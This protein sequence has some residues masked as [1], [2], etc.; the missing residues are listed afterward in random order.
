MRN[1]S[2]VSVCD[3]S[4]VLC[5]KCIRLFPKREQALIGTKL[6]AVIKS[7]KTKKGNKFKKSELVKAVVVKNSQAIKR[8]CGDISFY[9]NSAV[10]FVK[11]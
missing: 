9:T 11:R 7:V 2:S 6:L 5:V 8:L 3:N 10:C 4:G 1:F